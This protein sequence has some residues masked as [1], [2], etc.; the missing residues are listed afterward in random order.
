LIEWAALPWTELEHVARGRVALLPLGAVEEHGPHIATGADWHAAAELG[1][2]V[3]GSAGLILLPAVPYGQVW[4]LADYPGSLSVSNETLTALITD[5]GAGL[6]LAGIN[7]LVV[8]SCHLG[9]ITAMREAARRLSE[10]GLESLYLFYPGLPEAAAAV[11]TTAEVSKDIVHADEIE[12]SIF[13]ELVPDDVDM[14]RAEA[15]WPDLPEYFQLSPE[16]WRSFSS[17]GVFGDPT[18]ASAE[19]GQEIIARVEQRAVELIG[20]WRARHVL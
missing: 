7:G 8:L 15:E 18:A 16:R 13:L 20:A 4:S 17:S 19:K 1:R 6:R 5:I 2:R 14:S 12:T 3:A 11:R 10:Q 9:N